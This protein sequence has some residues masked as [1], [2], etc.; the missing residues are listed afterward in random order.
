M[1]SREYRFDNNQNPFNSL[2]SIIVMVVV[3]IGLFFVARFIL[4][5]LYFLAPIFFII[6]LIVDYKAVLGY[7][8]WL[9][10]TVKQNTLMGVGAI[11]L[12]LIFYPFVGLFLMGKALFKRKV[13]QMQQEQQR[14][15]KG[16]FVDY[17]E[18]E[19]KK[20]ELPRMEERESKTERQEKNNDRYDQFFE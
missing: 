17:E 8:K 15:E 2:V 16:E 9:V 20:L 18:V 19:E 11:A 4:R 14:I 7:G 5:I 13:K 1:K 3:L 12:S 6:A 10:S